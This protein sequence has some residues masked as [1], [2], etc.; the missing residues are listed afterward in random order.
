[1]R[2]EDDK[3]VHYTNFMCSRSS[4]TLSLALVGPRDMF[5]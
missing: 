1:M 5:I 2:T 4:K 3:G